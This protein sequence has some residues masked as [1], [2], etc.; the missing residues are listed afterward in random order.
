MYKLS[1]KK[2]GAAT[3]FSGAAFTFSIIASSAYGQEI[4]VGFVGDLSAT[5]GAGLG[6]A[7]VAGIDAA[8][9]D[10]NKSGGV[11]GRKLKLIIRDDQGQPARSIANV[12]ELI[13]SEKVA[14]IF[15]PSNSGNAMAWKRIPN[16][17]K[18]VAF[19]VIA[20]ATDITKPVSPGS[21]N[22]IFRDALYDRAQ[23]GAL[24]AYAEKVGA[25]KIGFLSENSGYGSSGLRDLQAQAKADDLNVVASEKLDATDTDMTSQLTKL[26]GA[27]VDTVLMWATGS[28]AGQ[29]MRSMEK[30]DYFPIVLGSGGIST[31]SFLDA[32]GTKLAGKPLSVRTVM[33]PETESQKQLF[34]RVESKLPNPTNFTW[35]IQGYDGVVLLAAA[36]RQAKST[37]GPQVRDALENLA[38]PVSGVFKTYDKPFSKT[39]HEALTSADVKFVRWT[40]GN[41]Q[42]YSDNTTKSLNLGEPKH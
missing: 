25:K 23:A 34:K 36:M 6:V 20:E 40:N 15:G 19:M 28:A 26:K 18:T 10:I 35:A 38:T 2:V 32:A 7:A 42:F 17:K 30:I 29:V 37:E 12:T 5:A 16:E 8:I 31:G 11:L 24:T 13:D 39:N 22:Y 27:G 4:N 1:L 21:D 9:E 3:M 14:A 41:V 33:S